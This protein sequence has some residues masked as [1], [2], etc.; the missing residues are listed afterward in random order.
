MKRCTKC[1]QTKP[2]GDFSP[3]R[4]TSDGCQPSCRR[5]CAD[6][7]RAQYESVQGSVRERVRKH[8]EL[9]RNAVFGHYGWTC[10]CCGTSDGLTIDHVNG[11]GKAHREQ[12]FSG[13]RGGQGSQFY[14]WLI[15]NN[16]PEGYQTLC[17]PCNASKKEGARCNLD[18]GMVNAA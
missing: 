4:H 10:A 12:L 1:Q 2:L 15:K 6:Y 17:R 11:D 5:C 3:N 7:A 8:A 13:K 18:H 9:L 16:F 14:R